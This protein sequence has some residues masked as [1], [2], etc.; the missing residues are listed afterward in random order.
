MATKEQLEA[1]ILQAG[2]SGDVEA[3]KVFKA[4]LDK[5]ISPAKEQPKPMVHSVVTWGDKYKADVQYPYGTPDD[6]NQQLSADSLTAAYPGV[7]FPH[8]S[9]VVVNH[10][11]A[12]EKSWYGNALDSA[13]DTAV[14]VLKGVAS[15]PD[16][17]AA[18]GEA[19][20]KGVAG[21]GNFL[22][23]G[24][25]AS[26]G[27]VGSQ[28]SADQFGGQVSKA[29]TPVPMQ[30][31]AG[32]LDTLYPNAKNSPTADAAQFLGGLAVPFPAGKAAP[33]FGYSPLARAEAQVAKPVAETALPRTRNIPGAPDVVAAGKQEGVRVFTSD[34]RP[35]K[36]GLGR[37]VNQTT[38]KIPF[39]GNDGILTIGGKAAQQ[40]ERIAAVDR[41]VAGHGGAGGK[42][43]IN[44][45]SADLTATRGAQLTKL[46]GIKN[47]II[48]GIPGIVTAD[49]SLAAVD[50]KIAELIDRKTPKSL[51]V[52]EILKGLRPE[53]EGKTLKQLEA[54]RSDELA[55]AFKHDNLVDIKE[56][57]EKSI[58]A[59]YD[60]LRKDMAAVISAQGNKGDFTQWQKANSKLSGMMGELDDAAF[61]RALQKAD[62]TPEGAKALIFSKTPS[63]LRRL[64]SGLS[65]VGQANG[66][67]AII[68]KVAEDSM[69][70]NLVIDPDKFMRGLKSVDEATRVFFGPAEKAHLDGFQRLLEATS[71]GASTKL[72]AKNL[73][74]AL[75]SAGAHTAVT[76]AA[77]KS[78]YI[79]IPAGIAAR[80]YESAP[81]RDMF[82]RLGKTSPG[83]KA[84][85]TVLNDLRV[86]IDTLGKQTPRLTMATLAAS[87]SNP[88]PQTA[89]NK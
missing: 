20:Q 56:L 55:N 52:A 8:R 25:G 9:T 28:S 17:L 66:R 36:T 73:M 16:T 54:L 65:A 62:M 31:L 34:V 42:D 21:I 39:I 27:T 83:S 70:S 87:Q 33:K 76:G 45:V 19:I 29:L 11:D 75:L 51:Q 38:S 10:N 47:S 72:D 88:D 57:G 2:A 15:L 18:G 67:S 86:A 5:V 85:A 7:K 49:K 30:S 13:S 1:A 71:Q 46:T 64:A 53:F 59:L 68:G 23:T 35:P 43:A 32:G 41:L 79:V 44:A 60:P 89:E 74:P 61:K 80:I 58:R 14:N 63:Q 48:D 81:M 82:L 40:E 12:A 24:G 4:E 77:I 78:P 6:Q 84:E 50:A 3:I 37:F 69:D 26:S 22:A